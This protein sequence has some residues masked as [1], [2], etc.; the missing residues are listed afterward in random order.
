MT[1]MNPLHT[2]EIV[3]QHT[4]VTGE[5]FDQTRGTGRSTALALK[6]LDIRW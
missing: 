5:Y 1:R 2:A 6:F 3:A 4:R